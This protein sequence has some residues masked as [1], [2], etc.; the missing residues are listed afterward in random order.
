MNNRK[1]DLHM[2]STNSDGEQPPE[3]VIHEAEAAGL[4]LISIT[5]HNMFTFLK[6]EKIGN[7]VVVPGVEFSV[8]YLVPAWN[9]TA[10]IHII[11]IFPSGV[12]PSDFDDI[13]SC[14]E[15]GKEDYVKAILDDLDTRG[16]HITMQEVIDV[17]KKGKHLGRHEIAKVLVS[18]GIEPDIEAAFD[19]QIGNFS[20]H[21]IPSTRDRKSVV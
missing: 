17:P 8:E 7:V 3:K 4:S 11:G 1:I 6:S 20:P 13:L 18:K 5:D 14:I 10:E 15:D 19:H 21:Y 12:V 2:H 9:E 16:I